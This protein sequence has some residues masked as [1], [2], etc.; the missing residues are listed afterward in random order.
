MKPKAKQE[1]FLL[2]VTKGALVPADQYT[3]ER[4]RAKGYNTNDVLTATL[5]KDRSTGFHRLV[6]V[7]GQLCAE[8]IDRFAGMNAHAVLKAI[9]YEGDIA[10]E[11]MMVNLKGFGMVE[12]RIPM[13]L[14]YE[15]LDEGDFREIFSAMC[16]H[17]AEQY[18]KGLTAE[19]VEEMTQVMVEQAA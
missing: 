15:S 9:Q 7:F 13:S 10:C 2:R 18:W 16:G 8:N 12:V 1:T 4:L 6:H 14:S 5:R 17:V 11:R 19:Q 3:Q